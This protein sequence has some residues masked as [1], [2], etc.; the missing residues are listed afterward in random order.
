MRKWHGELSTWA[1]DREQVAAGRLGLELAA[2][3]LFAATVVEFFDPA[4]IATRVAKADGLETL[5]A[6]RQSLAV[7]PGMSL[8]YA[9]RFRDEWKLDAG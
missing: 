9:R 1:E 5:A 3:L 8:A 7:S 4:V 2:W 6:A